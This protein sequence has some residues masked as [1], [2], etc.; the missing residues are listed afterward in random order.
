[1]WNLIV[2]IPDLC[3]MT[4]FETGFSPTEVKTH[5]QPGASG[6]LGSVKKQNNAE[7]SVQGC[8]RVIALSIYS[9]KPSLP[10]LFIS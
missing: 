3:T 5:S 2:L 9:M 10:L 1:M 6:I 7:A 4:Y 8:V